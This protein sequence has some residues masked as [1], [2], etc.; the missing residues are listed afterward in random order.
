MKMNDKE[1]EV[2]DILR[3]ITGENIERIDNILLGLMTYA[4]LNYSEGESIII[5]YF[6]KFKLI[7]E[8][9]LVTNQ[10]REAKINSFFITSE[11]LKENI[12]VYEDFKKGKAK[13]NAVPI[14]QIMDRQNEFSLKSIL[15]GMK[16]NE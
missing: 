6:G 12:G 2:L 10:G 7:Y 9:D 4:L 14:V 5:P 11:A 15:D 8:G 13:L 1:R 16:D 3:N